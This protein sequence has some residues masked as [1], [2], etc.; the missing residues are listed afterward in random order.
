MKVIHINKKLIALVLA[1]CTMQSIVA[2]NPVLGINVTN[3]S[4][5][6]ITINPAT[7]TQNIQEYD[8]TS[9]GTAIGWFSDGIDLGPTESTIIAAQPIDTSSLGSFITTITGSSIPDIPLTFKQTDSTNWTICCGENCNNN[10]CPK[11]LSITADNP[12]FRADPNNCPTNLV[13]DGGK[14]IKIAIGNSSEK[15]KIN[16][17][18]KSHHAH[19]EKLKFHA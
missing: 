10:P 17:E 3:N 4:D 12:G 11:N 18:K 14:C 15:E 2:D 8:D 9:A 13:S 5:D 19:N 1:T 6:Y 16:K 7:N